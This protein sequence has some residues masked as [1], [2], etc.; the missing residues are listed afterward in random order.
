MLISPVQL[1]TS[2]IGNL[3][4][5]I[6]LLLYVM[7]IHT[8]TCAPTATR[9]NNNCLRAFLF[10]FLWRCR[11]FRLFLYHYRFLFVWRVCPYVFSFRNVVFYLFVTT[12][13]IFDISL[14]C[15]NSINRSI[16]RGGTVTETR[17]CLLTL[18]GRPT[19]AGCA[20]GG[21]YVSSTTNWKSR[22]PSRPE[23]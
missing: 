23:W 14:S 17:T 10:S 7:T 22:S 16:N 11:F 2:R 3:T 15:D 1:T 20:S 12:G 8:H 13:W 9:S 18:P 6:L 4:R 19:H 21:I 5:L